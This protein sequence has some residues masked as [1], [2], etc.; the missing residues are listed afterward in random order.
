MRTIRS[1]IDAPLAPGI[2]MALP[3]A[4]GNHLVR[5]LRLKTGDVFN[6]FNGDGND[7]PA[8][9][10]GFDKKGANARIL[11]CHAVGNESPLRIHLY[12][13]IARG[14]KMD[15]ILQKATELGVNAFTPMVSDRT[16]VK[17]DSERSD[18]KLNHWLGVIR[19]A[20]EQSG[21][22]ILPAISPPISINQ[23]NGALKLEQ[24]Y[25]LE[26]E[27]TEGIDGL[28]PDTV[29]ELKLAIGPEGGFSERDIRLLQ[30]AGFKGLRIGP[31]I[32]R[33]ETAGIAAIAALQ[34]RFGDW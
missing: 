9:I 7:Y 3:E 30:T 10:T 15:W 21:R 6:L 17:L 13:S 19:S 12:Q 31:R 2:E 14:E 34:S 23:M 26:P 1:Y 8:E 18:K 16:E 27:G 25:Y 4:I 29:F 32:L 28:I 20:C 33:T 5:V 24:A 22:A 11:S